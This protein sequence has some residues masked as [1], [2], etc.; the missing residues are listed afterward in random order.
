MNLCVMTCATLALAGTASAVNFN[1]AYFQ[2]FDGLAQS[3]ATTVAGQGPHAIQ[4]V[5]GSTGMD[6]WFGA[7]YI[8]SS[9]STEFK[10]HDGSLAGSAG[11]GVVFFGTTGSS[12]RAL[13]ALPTS[14]QVSSFGLV[15]TNTSN[16][17]YTAL[18]V[19]YIGEQWR[20]GEANVLNVLNFAY[21]FGTSLN[22]AN[23]AFTGLNFDAPFLGGGEVAVNG[24]SPAFQT[25]I[26]NTITGLTWAPG[27][28]LV[29]R[30]NS[31]DLSGQD[32]GLAIDDLSIT[33]V[34]PTPGA[35]A[36][37]GLAGLVGGR[38]RRA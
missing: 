26:S 32:N 2:N 33:G 10:A 24:N 8:G 34:V 13:G 19:S 23:T 18:D 36:L 12:D 28:S 25:A 5:L 30:W 29:L 1:G 20:A 3:G 22:N 15:L 17:T 9:T 27:Q 16:D 4:G 11:R 38:R 35:I 37:L 31:V 14:N 21:G 6:G 7:N